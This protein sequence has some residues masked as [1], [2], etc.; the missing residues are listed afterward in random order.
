MA[1]TPS[2]QMQI[3]IQLNSMGNYI[4]QELKRARLL[5]KYELLNEI[6]DE[7]GSLEQYGFTLDYEQE[8]SDFTRAQGRVSLTNATTVTAYTVV[9]GNRTVNYTGTLSNGF[10]TAQAGVAA[11]QADAVASRWVEA[12]AVN[13][14]SGAGHIQLTLRAFLG[15]SADMGNLIALS[16]TGVGATASGATFGT[17]GVAPAGT[18]SPTANILGQL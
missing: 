16:A 1:P 7:L 11:I 15:N 10:T 12:V 5:S 18:N 2:V 4:A 6:E 3:R 14:G 17:G 8:D 13:D 9:I